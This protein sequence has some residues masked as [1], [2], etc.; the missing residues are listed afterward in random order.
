MFVDASALVSILLEEE[1]F[2]IFAACLEKSTGSQITPFV[3]ME[4]GLALLR[5]KP[6]SSEDAYTDIDDVLRIFKIQK[7]DLT[8]EMILAAIKAYER[9]GKGRHPARLNMGDCLS[10]GAARVLGVPMLYKGDDFAKTDIPS[11]L[12]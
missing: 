10:Y 1:D 5:E 4:A 7:A 3:M 11:A 8:P 6:V 2:P 12:A 9:Y